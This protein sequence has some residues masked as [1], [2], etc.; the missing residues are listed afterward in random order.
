MGEPNLAGDVDKGLLLRVMGRKPL[1]GST[2]LHMV[3]STVHA[4]RVH[5]G[6]AGKV[7]LM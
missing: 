4:C 5:L 3:E 2:S 7:P 6:C 1:Q